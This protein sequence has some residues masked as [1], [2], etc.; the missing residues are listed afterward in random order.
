MVACH[1]QVIANK[2]KKPKYFFCVT[3][4][5]NQGRCKAFLHPVLDIVE[6]IHLSF[7]PTT[8][9]YFSQ[10]AKKKRFQVYDRASELWAVETSEYWSC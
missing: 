5:S 3:T 7:K 4:F 2:D 10:R 6:D 9:W 1:F 8:C